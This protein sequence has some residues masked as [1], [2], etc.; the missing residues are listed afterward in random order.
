MDR[1]ERAASNQ[2]DEKSEGFVG[3]EK[4]LDGFTEEEPVYL[5]PKKVFR[6]VDGE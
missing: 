2:R 3:E 5:V 4:S 6:R 1:E